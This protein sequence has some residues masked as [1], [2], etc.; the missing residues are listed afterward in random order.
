P[1]VTKPLLRPI[2]TI[3]NREFRNTYGYMAGSWRGRKPIQ[4]NAIIALGVYKDESAIEDLAKLLR[5]DPRPAIRG[6]SAWSLGKIGTKEAKLVLE[7]SLEYEED[8]EV[9]F[10][11]EE[12]L[13]SLL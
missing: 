10:E 7:E 2:L 11:I 3:S 4:R 8:G 5:E 12:A 9:I 6:T 1:E 13:F